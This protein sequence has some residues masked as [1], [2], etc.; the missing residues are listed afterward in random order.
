MSNLSHTFNRPY[1]IVS[2][3]TRVF[4]KS[5]IILLVVNVAHRKNVRRIARTRGSISLCDR[6]IGNF[7]PADGNNSIVVS[8]PPRFRIRVARVR[9]HRI[10][11]NGGKGA[12]ATT[13][14]KRE[15][16]IDRREWR[17]YLHYII[18]VN[19]NDAERSRD[20]GETEIIQGIELLA[21]AA[22]KNAANNA[23]QPTHFRFIRHSPGRTTRNE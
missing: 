11:I 6:A 15:G 12:E 4:E 14:D 9:L 23:S 1:Q 21:G 8:G 2:R 10:R 20:R 7:I 5:D 16:R 22:T 19:A 3:R 18:E 13:S 17:M